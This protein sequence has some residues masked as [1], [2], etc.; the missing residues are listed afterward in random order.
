MRATLYFVDS[1]TSYDDRIQVD[2]A[3]NGPHSRPA[4]GEL[5]HPRREGAGQRARRPA[6]R[7]GDAVPGARGIT[8]P[9]PFAPPAF[10]E[11]SPPIPTPYN[12]LKHDYKDVP[13]VEHIS[14]VMARAAKTG[15][16]P[17]EPR[18][19]RRIHL[20]RS[21]LSRAGITAFTRPARRARRHS[22]LA[23]G[24]DEALPGSFVLL[25]R[26]RA[27]AVLR[28]QRGASGW[29]CGGYGWRRRRAPT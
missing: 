20:P 4:R 19:E 21:L 15:Q 9:R 28:S 1:I 11:S 24:G 27:G 13:P 25:R 10:A 16:D 7:R 8:T 22:R 6:V 23:P 5:R 14:Q 18:R 3:R 29:A 2:R 17:A 26:R 12:A